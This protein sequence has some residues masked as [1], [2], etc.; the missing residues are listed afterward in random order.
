MRRMSRQ[1]S[2]GE[3][4]IHTEEAVWRRPPTG[5]KGPSP[6]DFT[7]DTFSGSDGN[8]SGSP[9]AGFAGSGCSDLVSGG[10]PV[11][12]STRGGWCLGGKDDS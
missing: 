9:A 7:G 2:E 11:E 4:R 10:V 3:R 1:H 5:G 12:V 8:A 6:D